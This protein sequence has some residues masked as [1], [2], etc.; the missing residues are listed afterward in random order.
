MKDMLE[1]IEKILNLSE[2][3]INHLHNIDNAWWYEWYRTYITWLKNELAEVEDEIREKNSV[4]LEDELWDLFWDFI[5]LLNSLEQDGLISK[6][7]VFERCFKKYIERLWKSPLFEAVNWQ[8][9]KKKQKEELRKEHN[10]KYN[11]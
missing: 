10:E 7:R 1:H 3:R 9:T 4:Y 2:K 6:E 8:E 5:C 11:N